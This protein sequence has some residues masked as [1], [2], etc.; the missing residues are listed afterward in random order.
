MEPIKV[1]SLSMAPTLAEGD[2]L[3]VDK[4]SP[5]FSG[6][7]P[8]DIVVAVDDKGNQIVKRVGAVAG[9]T[10]EIYDSKVRIGKE[11]I[12]E[13]Y[14]KAY[15]PGGL[16]YAPLKVPAGEVFLI[17]DNRVNSI[18]SRNF[19]T[20][21]ISSITG[22]VVVSVPLGTEREVSSAHG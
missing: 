6:I 7:N 22:R 14:I 5:V 3:F 21:P 12:A 17:G 13:P 9:Q 16:F 10:F 15:N 11:E 18:D 1:T 20:I 2:V 19:G 8:G 4:L